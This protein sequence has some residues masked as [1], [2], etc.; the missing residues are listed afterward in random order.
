MTTNDPIDERR[1]NE[2][3]VRELEAFNT[4][5]RGFCEGLDCGDLSC[6]VCPLGHEVC[7]V[8]GINNLQKKYST[9]FERFI[10]KHY[11]DIAIVLLLSILAL[12]TR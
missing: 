1:Y 9:P 3:I 6:A 7:Q 10:A 8:L 12:V 4:M 5:I 2:E 11:K